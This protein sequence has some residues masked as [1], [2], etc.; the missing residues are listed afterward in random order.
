MPEQAILWAFP[1]KS[2][3]PC[4][5]TTTLCDMICKSEAVRNVRRD[6]VNSQPKNEEALRSVHDCSRVVRRSLSRTNDPHFA[7]SRPCHEGKATT[8]QH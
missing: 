7:G 8:M 3:K 6:L 4:C 1:A 5:E 2:T